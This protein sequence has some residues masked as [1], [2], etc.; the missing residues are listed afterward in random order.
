MRNSILLFRRGNWVGNNP[1]FEHQ[2][3][4]IDESTLKMPHQASMSGLVH[5]LG[6]LGISLLS[7]L[8]RNAEVPSI[9]LT[10]HSGICSTI[11]HTL[12]ISFFHFISIPCVLFITCI[13]LQKQNRAVPVFRHILASQNQS[14]HYHH[15]P[16]TDT[17][18]YIPKLTEKQRSFPVAIK[19]KKIQ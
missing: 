19:P 11:I 16:H 2:W 12:P 10:Q 18:W 6:K 17:V 5:P 14:L 1:A 4:G 8:K 3:N 7:V 15:K 9:S 13:N